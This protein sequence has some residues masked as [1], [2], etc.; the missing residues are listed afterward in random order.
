MAQPAPTPCRSLIGNQSTT[1][2]F[3]SQH[4]DHNGIASATVQPSPLSTDDGSY[5]ETLI[6]TIFGLVLSFLGVVLAFLQLRHMRIYNTTQVLV[7]V[8]QSSTFWATC[9][10]LR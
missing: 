6:F 1:P 4:T 3:R 2:S 8:L 5:S 7:G 10:Q 9:Y